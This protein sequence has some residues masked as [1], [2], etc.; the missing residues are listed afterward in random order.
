[1]SSRTSRRSSNGPRSYQRLYWR[2]DAMGAEHRSVRRADRGAPA[3]RDRAAFMSHAGP[4]PSSTRRA[5]RE[6]LAPP[7]GGTGHP[8]SPAFDF[9]LFFADPRRARLEHRRFTP[10]AFSTENGVVVAREPWPS[11]R[12]AGPGQQDQ[13]HGEAERFEGG[14]SEHAGHG[15]P[16]GE[17]HPFDPV[18]IQDVQ[19]EIDPILEPVLSKSFIKKGNSLAIKLATRR[20]TTRPTSSCTSPRS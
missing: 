20:W 9:A 7:G 17:R 15:A 14:D 1:M 5:G 4:F 16:H 18:L 8:A 11:D 2:E 3:R 6:D 10:D 13:E 19:E 12:P